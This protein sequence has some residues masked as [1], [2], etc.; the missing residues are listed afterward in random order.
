[1]SAA[2]PVAAFAC[3]PPQLASRVWR[4]ADLGAGA[5]QVLGSGW[6]ELDA[7]LPGGG[8]PCGSLNE[9]LLPRSPLLEWRLLGP[10]LR[11]AQRGGSRLV[12]VGPPATPYLPGLQGQGIDVGQLVWVRSR[13]TAESLWASEQ[14]LRS[15][16]ALALLAWLPGCRAQ[17]LR[18]LQVQAGGSSAWLFVLREEPAA[19]EASPAPL[20][21]RARCGAGWEL[22]VRLLKRRG[23]AHE[24]ELC[25]P[26]LPGGL[27][28]AL[29]GP[30]WPLPA[31]AP[32]PLSTPSR[33]AVG[34]TAGLRLA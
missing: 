13:D 2:V 6:A 21:V 5:T 22:R 7:E 14:L 16:A 27:E 24:G 17:A 9:I 20:R 34:R 4:G 23:P 32:H 11:A 18:R 10:A 19:A 26:S 30:P 29:P 3:V 28:A 8:W 1:M 25:L 31:Q 15:G 33:D 12:V